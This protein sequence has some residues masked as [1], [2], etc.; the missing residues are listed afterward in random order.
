MLQPTKYL[1]FDA[2]TEHGSFVGVVE[3][4]PEYLAQIK[5]RMGLAAKA[6]E[7]D[8][9]FAWMMF[10]DS[11]DLYEHTPETEAWLEENSEGDFDA[12]R[13]VVTVKKPEFPD[14]DRERVS[15]SYLQVDE[16]SCYWE[17]SPKHSGLTLESPLVRAD[18]ELFAE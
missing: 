10:Y 13:M 3:C 14:I 6:K 5:Q 1:I 17:V 12:T 2:S 15:Q 7:G 4:T 18:M 11:V 16:R 9:G 8:D